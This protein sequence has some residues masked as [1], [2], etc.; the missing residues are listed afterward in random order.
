MTTCKE[1]GVP[2]RLFGPSGFGYG[3]TLGGGGR[4]L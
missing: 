2:K 4:F 3:K 1:G